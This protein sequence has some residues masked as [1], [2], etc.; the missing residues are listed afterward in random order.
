MRNQEGYVAGYNGQLVVTADQVIVGAILSQHPVDRTLLHP[1]LEVCRQQLAEAGIRPKLRT[2]LAD[3]GYPS[4]ETFTRGEEQK[5]RLLVPLAKDPDK[6]LT[7]TLARKCDLAKL[8]PRTARGRTAADLPGAPPGAD[9]APRQPRSCGRRWVLVLDRAIDPR[10][11]AG[12][13][14]QAR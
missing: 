14:R 9:R 10:Q 12:Q 5:L 11:R 6:H 13:P 2:V 1:L 3:A 4:E 8:P 7:R